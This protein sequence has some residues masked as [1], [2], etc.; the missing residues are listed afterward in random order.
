MRSSPGPGGPKTPR[1]SRSTCSA[2]SR[3]E[4]RSAAALRL[5]F[6]RH[7]DLREGWDGSVTPGERRQ[8][9]VGEDD[10][11]LAGLR[12]DG[13]FKQVKQVPRAAGTS[14]AECAD[15]ADVIRVVRYDDLREDN[16]VRGLRL[17]GVTH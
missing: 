17:E 13:D 14:G 1:A 15:D 6:P 8:R 12:V 4:R 3:R 11:R 5:R 16:P 7:D 10:G 9:V 2:W